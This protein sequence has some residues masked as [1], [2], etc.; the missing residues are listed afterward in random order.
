M[1]GAAPS[2]VIRLATK[3][4]STSTFP[5]PKLGAVVSKQGRVLGTGT[6]RIGYCS[7]L[8]GAYPE[9]THAEVD[10]IAKLLKVRRFSDL[11]GATLSV[12]RV[13]RGGDWRIARPCANCMAI[14]HAVGIKRINYTCNGN[15]SCSE[16]VS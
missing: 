10:A 16:K 3:L 13:N 9:S 12:A 8:A 2:Y 1:I 7:V 4:A 15:T 11:R 5:G 6:N 14:I